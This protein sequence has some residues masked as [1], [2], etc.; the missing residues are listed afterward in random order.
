MPPAFMRVV[1]NE[2]SAPGLMSLTRFVPGPVPSLFHNSEPLIPSSPAKKSVSPLASIR[3]F[4][5]PG[6]MFLTFFVP[7]AR[8]VTLPEMLSGSVVGPEE[9]SALN[10]DEKFGAGIRRARI[11]IFHA[12]GSRSSSRWFSTAPCHSHRSRTKNMMLPERVSQL[13]LEFPPPGKMFLTSFVPFSVPSLFHSSA[14]LDVVAENRT[15]RP[16]TA[17]LFG[18]EPHGVGN[19]VLNDDRIRG[20]LNRA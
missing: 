10:V 18:K 4:D 20:G 12:L 7:A 2:S 17:K 5:A 13:G 8:S 19:D 11:D 3:L 15:L 6:K 16:R 14:P 9:Q 1:G